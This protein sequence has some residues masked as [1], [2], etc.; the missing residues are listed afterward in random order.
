VLT[1]RQV[2]IHLG[3]H[4]ETIL[5]WQRKGWLPGIR[6]PGGALR[7]DEAVLAATLESWSTGESATSTRGVS[8]TP[9]GAAEL[10]PYRDGHTLA[11]V[12][13]PVREEQ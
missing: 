13:H 4:T 12:S 1:A 3:F 2:A 11:A 6:T 8:A 10:R 9:H 7:F 5:R